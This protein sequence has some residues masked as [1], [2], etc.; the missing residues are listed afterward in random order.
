M[1][2]AL[3]ACLLAAVADATRP[4]SLGV[5]ARTRTPALAE[6]VLDLALADDERIVALSPAAVSLYRWASDGL[7]LEARL[8]LPGRALPV[9]TPG[10]LLSPIDDTGAFWALAS[11]LPSATLYRIEGRRLTEISQADAMPWP[12]SPEG[13]RFRAGSNLLQARIA[14]LGPGPYLTVEP[15]YA[16]DA[17]ARLRDAQAETTNDAPRVG[18]TL[19]ALGS[20]LLAASRPD[21]P[22]ASDEI[23]LLARGGDGWAVAQA[24]PIEG[25]VRALAA[26]PRQGQWRLVAAVE[27]ASGA[28]HLVILDL[29]A[30]T[31]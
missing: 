27:E 20:S 1:R 9:R 2:A 15:G 31:P 4:E 23:L 18:P 17:D 19:A 28:T 29:A 6:P 16:V 21:A 25:A 26:R 8:L 10:G 13:L 14:S 11:P 3:L 24:I 12:G 22:G 30:A 7:G 5:T